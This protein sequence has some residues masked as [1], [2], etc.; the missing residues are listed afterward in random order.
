[1]GGCFLPGSY[2]FM[3]RTT[4]RRY[5]FPH[6]VGLSLEAET[7]ERLGHLDDGVLEAVVLHAQ[8]VGGFLANEHVGAL[9]K[10]IVGAWLTNRDVRE[11]GEVLVQDLS[12]MCILMRKYY[13][14]VDVVLSCERSI[15]SDEAVTGGLL[16][17]EGSDV[18]SCDYHKR[19]HA[20]SDRLCLPSLTLTQ[21]PAAADRSSSFF[22]PEAYW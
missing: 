21:F 2:H 12:S 19:M 14:H 6:R 15:T 3:H 22:W 9:D 17:L 8:D 7:L 13:S 11:I 10:L 20:W 16:N 4:G 1:M 5:F 18:G